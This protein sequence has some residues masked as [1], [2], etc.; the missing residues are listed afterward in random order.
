MNYFL[1]SYIYIYIYTYIEPFG[2]YNAAARVGKNS[3]SAAHKRCEQ[4]AL[5][6]NS[7]VSIEKYVV[8]ESKS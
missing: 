4:S 1:Y 3:Y 7:S 2:S 8:V 5:A 6:I